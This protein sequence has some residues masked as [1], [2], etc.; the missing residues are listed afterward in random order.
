[1]GFSGGLAVKDPPA[2]AGDIRDLGSI[3]G[4]GRS[5][6]GGHGNPL[7]R[8]YLEN[9]H[10]QR[11]LTGYSPR[12]RKESD[13]TERLSRHKTVEAFDTGGAEGVGSR[14]VQESVHQRH[15]SRPLLSSAWVTGREV[16]DAMKLSSG[17]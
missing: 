1:M 10:G 14:N 8:S 11:S 2:S 16:C 17:Y 15:S 5:P 4:S 3:P 12:G 13:M 7:Q 9:L 6:G